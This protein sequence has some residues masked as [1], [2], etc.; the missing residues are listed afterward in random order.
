MELCRTRTLESL[1]ST[2]P[3]YP[4]PTKS[5][6]VVHSSFV[7]FARKFSSAL[8]CAAAILAAGCH[9]NPYDSDY[10]IGWVTLTDNPGDFTSYIVNVDSVTLIGENV[11][12][13]TAVATP[14]TVDFSKLNN[15]A[16]LW[17]SA[18]IPND[19]YK[20][21]IITLDYTDAV[22]SVL[23]NGKSE[24]ATVTD[25]AG[26]AVTTISITVNF[27]PVNLLEVTP[28]YA[29]TSAHLLAIDFDLAA[30]NIVNTA[31]STPT[32]VVR[33]FV[34]IA[35][36]P[37]DTKL[38]RVRGPLINTSV[39]A[40]A[41]G[42]TVSGATGT[43]S[44]YV[45]PFYDEENSLG[46][47]SLFNTP[48]TIYSIN[49]ASYVGIA[50][51]NELQQL[52][53]GTTMTAAYT[54][55]VPT[56]NNLPN[57]PA[58]AGIFYPVY[59]VAGSTLEDV[60]TEGLSGYV[61]A[62]SGNT[63]TLSGSTLTINNYETTCNA[64]GETICYNNATTQLLVAPGTLVTEDDSTATGLNSNSISVGQY[65]SARGEYEL[66]A[67]GIVTL[68][69]TGTSS[70]NTGS[71][72][73][74]S[75]EIWGSLV[76]ST[77]DSLVMNLQTINGW[78]ASSYDF[79]GNGASAGQNPTAAAFAV[80][81]GALTVPAGV[82]AGDPLWVDGIFS[83]YASAPPDF[84]ATAV[85]SEASVQVAGGTGTPAG[86]QTCGVGSQVCDP[87]SLQAS[88]SATPTGTTTPFVDFGIAGF[89]IDLSN[90]QLV[91]AVIRVGP[92]SI[93][94][95]SQQATNPRVVPTKLPRTTT[96]SPLYAVGNPITSSTTATVLTTMT[97]I[98]QYSEFPS[99]VEQV[100]STMTAA[101]P[102]VQFEARGVY[103]RTTNTFT[104][105]SIN[106]VL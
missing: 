6:A 62:R 96:F 67:S 2:Q 74:M 66:P 44:V 43:Y 54:T 59:V 25:T 97:A 70:E 58:T 89:A 31:P 76:S 78:P 14:E 41:T 37:A 17:G 27:D 28:T 19:V 98:S 61:T 106:L 51:I 86:T 30:S 20:Q 93:D 94:L 23:V 10:G 18:S 29:S 38:I 33:P 91:S 13:I 103:N 50:G 84:D 69:A 1:Y 48:S 95:K 9:G 36:Q 4:F 85:N 72:R 99:F 77:A 45:R 92:E 49:G 15:I 46:S 79:S 53:A 57:P 87:A 47:L 82:V 100:N 102:P 63:L 81:T 68:D 56:V 52:S 24:L 35:T 55:F 105:T 88:W 80:N 7:Q 73:I 12:E 71:V 64:Y 3:K 65:I 5:E 34:T 39:G 11:G 75:S 40:A 8:I 22:I 32:V 21:A 90:A 16:E 42:G 26:A 60:Y 104:A 101:N 83:P